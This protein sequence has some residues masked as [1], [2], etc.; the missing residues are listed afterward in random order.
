MF[1]LAGQGHHPAGSTVGW[2]SYSDHS[3]IADLLHLVVN[4]QDP[5]VAVAMLQFV[6]QKGQLLVNSYMQPPQRQQHAPLQQHLQEFDRQVNAGELEQL[7]ATAVARMHTAVV[8]QLST[9]P[10]AK[11]VSRAAMKR[12]IQ[13]CIVHK[14]PAETVGPLLVN[15]AASANAV[16][17]LAGIRT[18]QEMMSTQL[19]RTEMDQELHPAEQLEVYELMK[20][21]LQHGNAKAVGLLAA[22]CNKSPLDLQQRALAYLLQTALHAHAVSI[23]VFTAMIPGTQKLP[24]ERVPP[25]LLQAACLKFSSATTSQ[26]RSCCSYH[27]LQQ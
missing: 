15:F 1:L 16:A 9:L 18:S 22:M 23:K 4:L 21:A 19:Q 24:A 20:S 8:K 2:D 17:A 14:P 25:L 11:Q 3:S 10:A 12:I 6:Q 27:V 5:S 13:L 26:Q 7:L